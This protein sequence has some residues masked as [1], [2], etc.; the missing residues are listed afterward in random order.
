MKGERACL[1]YGQ[2]RGLTAADWARMQLERCEDRPPTE[3]DAPVLSTL[4]MTRAAREALRLSG[5]RK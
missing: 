2:A 4:P 3:D 5:V 1:I